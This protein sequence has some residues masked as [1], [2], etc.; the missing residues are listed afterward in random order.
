RLEVR[1][2]HLLEQRLL[3]ARELLAL[4]GELPA[5]EDRHLVRE[6]VDL[7]LLRAVLVAQPRVIAIKTSDLVDQRRG[8]LAQRIRVHPCQLIDR[9]HGDESCHST[10]RLNKAPFRPRGS[11]RRPRGDTTASRSPAR[12]TAPCSGSRSDPYLRQAPPRRTSPDAAV[13]RTATRRS[14]RAPAPSCGSPGG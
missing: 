14:R 12:A 6:L 11:S 5:L 13:A 4:R 1:I 3:F 8:E 7:E 10:T 2:E 9:V